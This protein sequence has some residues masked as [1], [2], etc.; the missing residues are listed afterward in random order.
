VCYKHFGIFSLFLSYA[1]V[2]FYIQCLPENLLAVR[3]IRWASSTMHLEKVKTE[4]LLVGVGLML[5]CYL[6]TGRTFQRHHIGIRTLWVPVPTSHEMSI[7]NTISSA[8]L[9]FDFISTMKLAFL[10]P[11]SLQYLSFL[12]EGTFVPKPIANI[13]HRELK[14]RNKARCWDGRCLRL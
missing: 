3:S 7:Y 9:Y 5:Q 1:P 8:F 2:I 14:K 4:L 12:M 6:K 10:H 11:F 13:W